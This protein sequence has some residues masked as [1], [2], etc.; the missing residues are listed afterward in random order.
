MSQTV[1]QDLKTIVQGMID[2]GGDADLSAVIT[3]IESLL[4]K[5]EQAIKHA[6]HVGYGAGTEYNSSP[7][8]SIEFANNYFTQNFNPI[9]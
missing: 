2:N 4:P 9:N 1:L 7:E 8:K 3:H 6:C 5:E